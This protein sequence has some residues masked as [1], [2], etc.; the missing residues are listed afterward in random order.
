MEFASPVVRV[1]QR[2]GKSFS[3]KVDSYDGSY[4]HVS[5]EGYRIRNAHFGCSVPVTSL[6]FSS[7]PNMMAFKDAPVVH[8]NAA[9]VVTRVVGLSA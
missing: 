8:R 4:H 5:E 7:F 1:T 6:W 2:N 3:A 9:R